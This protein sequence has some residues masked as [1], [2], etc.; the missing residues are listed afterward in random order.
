MEKK[1]DIVLLD[2]GLGQEIHRQAGE[3][4]H[5]L[6]SVRVM[7]DNP[8]V[9]K[10]VHEDFIRAGARVLTINSY[11]CT[12]TRLGRHGYS[13]WFENLQQ[14][15]FELAY[16]ARSEA[17]F[18]EQEVNIAGCLSPL[19]GS[20]VSD[21]RSFTAMKQEYQ[22]IV[23]VQ[24]PLIDL[25]LIE[26]LACIGEAKAAVEATRGSG[27]PVLLSFTLSDQEP[28]KLRSGETI[29]EAIDALASYDLKGLLFNCS[30]PET[31]AKGFDNLEGINIP[32]GGYANGFTSVEP[33]KPGGTVD[34]LTAR[35]DLNQENY[36]SQVMNWVE[37]GATIV[38]GCCEVGP[39]YIS[40]L[41]DKLQA[42]GYRTTPFL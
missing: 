10:K 1:R 5:P 26:T 6:W 37:D 36:A 11:T 23:D 31:I 33:L 35:Q 12:P 28:G 3:P 20:Y 15:A 2:G 7:M 39:S 24:A 34:S 8:E 19:V 25:F 22:Q 27:K 14:K 18:S 41:R 29:A 9:V 17:G 4:A 40:E 38:G 21:K 16:K 32:F 13:D 30:F 42:K